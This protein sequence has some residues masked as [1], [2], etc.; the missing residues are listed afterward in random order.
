MGSAC[1]RMLGLV[2]GRDQPSGSPA[3][4]S[5]YVQCAMES[6]RRGEGEAAKKEERGRQKEGLRGR[7]AERKHTGT[8]QVSALL[9]WCYES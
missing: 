4:S 8:A 5:A 7:Q 6:V 3:K 1:N 2:H 9:L